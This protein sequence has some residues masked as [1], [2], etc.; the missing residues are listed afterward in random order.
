MVRNY[1]VYDVDDND[2][3]DKLKEKNTKKE[4][5]GDA[6]DIV[7]YGES[8]IEVIRESKL[9]EIVCT[10]WLSKSQVKSCIKHIRDLSETQKQD[11]R[12]K[13]GMLPH[14]EFQPDN[15]PAIME[16]VQNIIDSVRNRESRSIDKLREKYGV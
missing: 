4:N 2:D 11:I 7:I 12:N 6:T 3:V 15:I 16:D 5:G 13:I 1:G 8:E 9:C 10:N 14:K